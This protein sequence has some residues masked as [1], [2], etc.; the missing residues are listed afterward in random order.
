MK[1][2]A[3]LNVG[4]L[5]FALTC[6]SLGQESPPPVTPA[7]D[8]NASP[9]KPSAT[10]QE[11]V[12]RINVRRKQA[13]LQPLAISPA[14]FEAARQ[15]SKAMAQQRELNHTLKDKDLPARLKEAGYTWSRCAENIARGQQTPAEV[16]QTW[17]DSPGH[18]ANLLQDNATQL[19][20]AVSV[21]ADGQAYWTLVVAAPR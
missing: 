3:V 14:L 17:M 20:V 6:E 7:T 11:L 1:V 13:K 15:H 10:E 8:S 16:M 9:F 19:G 21:G 5:L 4:L 2:A 18:R 12:D